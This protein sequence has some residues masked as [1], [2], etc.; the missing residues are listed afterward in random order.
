[1]LHVFY[2]FCHL[3]LNNEYRDGRASTIFECKPAFKLIG[4]SIKSD[5]ETG[6]TQKSLA[7][8]ILPIWTSQEGFE[9]LT[10][11]EKLQILYILLTPKQMTATNFIKTF[12]NI[13]L[14]PKQ[15]TGTKRNLAT[16]TNKTEQCQISNV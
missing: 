13:L 3:A 10:T 7:H 4:S 12:S 11:A 6:E 2:R 14:T 5:G 16:K 15:I 8:C 1:M 9:G